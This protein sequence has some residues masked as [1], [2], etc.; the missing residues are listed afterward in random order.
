M[1]KLKK[2]VSK[3]TQ[4]TSLGNPQKASRGQLPSVTETNVIGLPALGQDSLCYLKY[5]QLKKI[6]NQSSLIKKCSNKTLPMPCNTGTTDFIS[7][8]PCCN[9]LAFQWERTMHRSWVRPSFFSISYSLRLNRNT[10][11]YFIG[12]LSNLSNIYWCFLTFLNISKDKIER[13]L[14]KISCH[15][16]G[17]LKA[18]C[19]G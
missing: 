12:L 3:S 16:L 6:F 18:S 9:L 2:G 11:M 8:P 15:N 7:T 17:F 13:T 19:F 5:T 10:I 4:F 1:T 14:P